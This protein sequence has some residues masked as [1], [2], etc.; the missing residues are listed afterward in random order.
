MSAPNDKIETQLAPVPVIHICESCGHRFEGNFCNNCGEKVLMASDRTFQT[1]LSNFLLAVTV[2]DNKF[3]KTLWLIVRKPGTLSKEYV[4]GRR[5][6]Y[7]RPLQ[8]FFILN[9]FYFLFP[10]LQLFN[11]SLYTQ[12]HLQ[13]H[14]RLARYLVYSKV[15]N[16][17]LA[18][19]GYSLMYND[20]STSLAK[21]LI[22][23]F[24]LVACVPMTIIYRKKNRYF[25]DHMALS[26]EF[27]AFNLAVNA[28][29]L[30]GVLMVTSKIFHL[31]HSGWEKYLDDTTLTIIF[32]ITNLYFLVSA[33]RTFYNQKGIMLVVKVVLGMLGLFVALEAYRLVLFLIT[34]WVLR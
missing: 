21:L 11:T 20:K 30:S 6:N 12:M 8:L 27:T 1:F 26:V 28:I 22:I 14:R 7:F 5:V 23:V 3:L 15:G 34:F 29:A 9:L 33:G 4:E 17:P 24:V 25:T 31:S 16:D 18:L 2:T 32:V 13:P 10:V 19:E